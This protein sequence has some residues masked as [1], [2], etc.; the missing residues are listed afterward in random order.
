M[1]EWMTA[2]NFDCHLFLP[3][4]SPPNRVDCPPPH[5]QWTWMGPCYRAR[6]CWHILTILTATI[7]FLQIGSMFS[8]YQ[9]SDDHFN[10]LPTWVTFSL[11]VW[12][13]RFPWLWRLLSMLW[14]TRWGLD[15]QKCVCPVCDVLRGGGVRMM[16]CMWL[17]SGPPLGESL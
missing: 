4:R 17:P 9:P 5:L 8:I 6:W 11:V 15:F 12:R 2:A 10:R 16:S 3:T 1:I 7:I 14:L 13:R